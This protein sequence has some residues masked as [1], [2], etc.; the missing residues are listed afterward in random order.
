MKVGQL[1]K[2]RKFIRRGTSVVHARSPCSVTGW[3]SFAHPALCAYSY[4]SKT[5]AKVTTASSSTFPRL[6]TARL[7]LPHPF[8]TT[9]HPRREW[10]C[11]HCW[12]WMRDLCFGCTACLKA[13]DSADS[14]I[15]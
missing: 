1:V 2:V 7:Q 6:P 12:S 15:L 5:S 10:K 3:N 8:Q 4:P 9:K 13:V 14:L 11:A